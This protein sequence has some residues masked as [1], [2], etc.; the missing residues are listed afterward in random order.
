[1]E[2]SPSLASLARGFTSLRPG[3]VNGNR[4]R[5]GVEA[6]RVEVIEGAAGIEKAAGIGKAAYVVRVAYVVKAAEHV[7]AASVDFVNAVPDKVN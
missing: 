2:V 5:V 1:M 4:D 3:C 7:K 6:V